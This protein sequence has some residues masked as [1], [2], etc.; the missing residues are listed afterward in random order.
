MIPGNWISWQ[1]GGSFISLS[2]VA[3]NRKLV[4][5]NDDLIFFIQYTVSNKS[6]EF[7]SV[8]YEASD[9]IVYAIAN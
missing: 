5:S 8:K 4:N 1:N 3:L 2:A 7:H 6:L 9:I